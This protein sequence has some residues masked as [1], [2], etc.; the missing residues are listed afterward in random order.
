M[1]VLE[2]PCPLCGFIV[3]VTTE[4]TAPGR[5]TA[6]SLIDTVSQHVIDVHEQSVSG[7]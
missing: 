1:I 4:E 3:D 7:M 6:P 5:I 2:V